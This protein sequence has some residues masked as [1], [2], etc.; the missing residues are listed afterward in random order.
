[1]KHFLLISALLAG[2]SA[3]AALIGFEDIVLPPAGHY[4]GSDGAGGFTSGG[5]GFNNSFTDWGG[6]VSTWDG[7]AVSSL[8]PTTI[9]QSDIDDGLFSGYE[10]F[11]ATGGAATG[12]NFAVG[13]VNDMGL[14]PEITLPTGLDAPQSIAVTNTLRAWGS[15]TYG[16]AFAKQFGTGANP[17]DFFFLTIEGL[18]AANNVLGSVD[19]YL[20]DFRSPDAAAH[21]IADEWINVDLTSIGADVSKLRFTLTS[22]DNGGFGMNTPSYFAIDNL[23][24][25]PE[26]SEWATLAGA[27][28]FGLVLLR[29]RCR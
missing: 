19:A 9:S 2:S 28:A 23:V 1:M 15:M 12:S 6:G 25:V 13:F 8:G 10:L 27:L 4:T 20:A 21:F 16:D 11:S 18:D 7:F 14:T 22:S 29:R 24:V 17:N 5:V 26:P 3:Q